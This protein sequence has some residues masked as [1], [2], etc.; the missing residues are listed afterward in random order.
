MK[1][2]TAYT[3]AFLA[4]LFVFFTVG[5]FTL[6]SPRSTGK[7]AY[8]KAETTLYYELEAKDGEKLGAVYANIGTIYTSAGA[9]TAVTL[10]TS[11]SAS[12]SV[13]SSYWSK[14]GD[15]AVIANITP[16]EKGKG[17]ANYN[18]IP[19]ATGLSVNAKKLSFT[20]TSGLQ[21][22]EIVCLNTAGERMTIGAYELGDSFDEKTQ[23]YSYD[24]QS[25]FTT[26]QSSYY[27]FT[28]EEA[29]CL[30]SVDS[31]L[32]GKTVYEGTYL[33]DRNFNYLSTVLSISTV[34]AFGHSAFALRLPSF[35]ASCVLL[36][37]AYL[38]VRELTKSD[39]YSFLFA[40][41]LAFGGL[42]VSVGRLGAPYMTVASALVASLYFMYRFFARGISSGKTVKG[43][44]NI[45]FSGIF[46][47]FALA[48][49]ASSVFPVAGIL[50]LFGFGLRRQYKAYRLAAA[51]LG[52]G[53]E[54][55]KQKARAVYNEKTR[56][57]Y[58]FAALSFV[59]TTAL[60]LLTAAAI[61]LS[62][63]VK[64][65][66]AADVGFVTIVWKGLCSSM[67]SK[68]LNA[69]GA[70]NASNVFAWW[71]P[72]KAATVYAGVNGVAAGNYLAWNVLPNAIATFASLFA[73]VGVSIKVV[74]DLARKNKDKKALRIRRT[75]IL[76]TA[77][78][79]AAMLAGACKFCVTPLYSVLFH[80]LYL[81]FLPL[82][83]TLLPEGGD[84]TKGK[85][86][87][88][89][90]GVWSLVVLVAAVFV[91]SLPSVYGFTTSSTWAKWFGWTGF[92]SNGYFRI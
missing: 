53:E 19:L 11:S 90:V 33:L 39:K 5:L 60:L 74:Y 18:W 13:S 7:S 50:T 47:A 9:D 10:K 46:S 42:T 75:Y 30:T 24:A 85:K 54:K 57:S 20:A 3:W 2:I 78:L 23:S 66:D 31:V 16:S 21:L 79:L 37:F 70:A 81:G 72:V 4:L 69:Y 44:L 17:G 91:M 82:A 29:Y 87:L 25:S 73:F 55:A 84:M 92:L 36:T 67:R 62:A 43:G 68:T 40:L 56:V 63:Y 12:P 27:N 1:K 6:G 77:G 52:D 22:N 83:A 38:L 26:S 32:S 64:A 14:F 45:L 59:M 41:V 28:Q 65:Y 15:T 58:G 76:L 71:L 48:I 88:A 34:A 51:K 35:L 61:C 49:D 86:L 8:V 80:T 89:E